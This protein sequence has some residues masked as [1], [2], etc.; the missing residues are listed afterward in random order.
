MVHGDDF[1]FWI[2]CSCAVEGSW[3]LGL[4]FKRQQL[5]GMVHQMHE[6]VDSSIASFGP[7]QMGG[8]T[9]AIGVTHS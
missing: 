6:K 1:N 5:L 3:K 8:S 2:Q 9:R 7:R 4:S